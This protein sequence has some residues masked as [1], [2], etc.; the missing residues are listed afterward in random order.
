MVT[1]PIK[2]EIAICPRFSAQFNLKDDHASLRDFTELANLCPICGQWQFRLTYF[3]LYRKCVGCRTL[4][5]IDCPT[6][7]TVPMVPFVAAV[8]WVVSA[9]LP[10]DTKAKALFVYG[11]MVGLAVLAI[12]LLLTL[13]TVFGRFV[14]VHFWT[15]MRDEERLTLMD[16]FAQQRA[17]NQARH[18]STAPEGSDNGESVFRSH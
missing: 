5:R 15:T 2:V 1:A 10:V 14:P 12:L 18:R 9:N 13:T 16:E 4:L 7:C 6:W 17:V 8:V 3:C 11:I